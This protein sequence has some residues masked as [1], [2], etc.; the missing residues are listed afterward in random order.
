MSEIKVVINDITRLSAKI[1]ELEAEITQLNAQI[2]DLETQIQNKDVV[3]ETLTGRISELE[4]EIST[5]QGQVVELS[6]QVATLTTQNQALTQQIQT[7]NEQISSLNTQI[8]NLNTQITNMNSAIETINGETV[9][10]PISYL[11]ETKSQILTALQNKGS[12]AT[13]S[14]TFR[15]YATEIAQLNPAG[16][17]HTKLLLRFSKPDSYGDVSMFN[18]PVTFSTNF[19]RSS[20]IKKFGDY[21]AVISGSS[22]LSINRFEIPVWKYTIEFWIYMSDIFT[23]NGY[24]L[25]YQ[26]SIVSTSIYY[27]K[28]FGPYSNTSK[29]TYRVN[30]VYEHNIDKSLFTLNTWH[31]VAYTRNNNYWYTFLDGIKLE[32]QNSSNLSPA[33]WTGI[34]F[35]LGRDLMQQKTAYIDEFRISDI[36]R[37]TEDFTPPTAPF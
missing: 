7:L 16:D 25:G 21:S 20:T 17:L 33:M 13:S 35:Y 11:A 9:L 18:V 6:A 19:T 37:Y 14:T 30:N 36:C 24:C 1:A 15:N 31:H 8:A 5:L 23:S 10:N 28:L 2:T 26:Y 34:D 32:E 27:I 3:I 4:S 22:Y 12:S 29:L